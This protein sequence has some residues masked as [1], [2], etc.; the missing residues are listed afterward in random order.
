MHQQCSPRIV[1]GP[2][3]DL[4][5]FLLSSVFVASSVPVIIITA[6]SNSRDTESDL[7]RRE[8][9]APFHLFFPSFP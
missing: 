1:H 8:L 5:C 7:Y 3:I 2:L 9:R 4:F 6:D